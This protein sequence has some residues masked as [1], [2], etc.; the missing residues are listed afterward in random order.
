MI[1]V[2]A[3]RRRLI[4][5]PGA[6]GDCILALPA[7]GHLRAEYTE[8]WAPSPVLPLLRFASVIRSIASTGLDLLGLPD[9]EPPPA[10]L[11]ALASF[12]SVVSWYGASRPEFRA[13]VERF[14][15]TFF[16]ALPE[17][18]GVHA[19]DWFLNLVGGTGPAIP[20]ICCPRSDRGFALIH[21][22]SGSR[23]KNWPLERF[24]A[25]AGALRMPVEWCAG[26]EEELE[27]A[28]RLDDLYALA[29]RIAEA[30]VYI[31]NDSGI[32]H[33]AAAV[34]TPVVALFGPTDPAIWAPRGSRV[35][36]VST[37]AS[38]ERMDRI[39]VDAVL[40]AVQKLMPNSP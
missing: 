9:R 4:I 40:A 11:E 2:P 34:G 37:P 35:E 19:A 33:L 5:R 22:F 29:C 20:R 6:I 3:V 38:G 25:V 32:T 17:N 1:G 8:V 26:P 15:F 23:K 24:R 39:P 31:G 10:L 36:V 7:M 28:V 30:S 18:P 16:K 14:P 12:D 27:G 13:A 21:P